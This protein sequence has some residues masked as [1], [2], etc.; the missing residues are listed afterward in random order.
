MTTKPGANLNFHFMLELLLLLQAKNVV[1][2]GGKVVLALVF[3]LG[4]LDGQVGQ[5][6]VSYVCEYVP[7]PMEKE[8]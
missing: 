7:S 5:F 2:G 4:M 8:K 6:P 3:T 1:K